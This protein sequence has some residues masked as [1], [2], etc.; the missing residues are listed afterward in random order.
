MQKNSTATFIGH[1]ECSNLQDNLIRN[2]I[3]KLVL[4][5]IVVFLNGGMGDFDWKCAR[6]VYEMK[7]KYP[8]IQ[9]LLVIPY[10]NFNIKE[11]KYFDSIIYPDG[12]EKYYFKSAI[13]KRNNYL[14]ENSSYAICY[15]MHLW[16]GAATTYKKALKNGVTI[17][18][19]GD[20]ENLI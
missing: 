16:G 13:P 19:V 8:Y 2:E 1:R 11:V 18:N 7:I 15:I 14:V 4:K 9:N 6:L 3:E 12:F 5:G 10:L 17:I 20:K